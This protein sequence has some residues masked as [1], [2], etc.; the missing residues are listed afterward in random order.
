MHATL[1]HLLFLPEETR[2]GVYQALTHL[3]YRYFSQADQQEASLPRAVLRGSWPATL[4][5]RQSITPSQIKG[6]TGGE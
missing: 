2:I 3:S 6:G 5:Q 4:N 1:L